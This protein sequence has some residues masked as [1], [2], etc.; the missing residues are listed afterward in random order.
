MAMYVIK[1]LHGYI[2]KDGRRTREKIP[3]KL[4][5]FEDRKQSKHLRKIGGRV[6]PL[7]EVKQHT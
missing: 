7:T 3:D 6:K 2:G 5:V 4:W 1:V